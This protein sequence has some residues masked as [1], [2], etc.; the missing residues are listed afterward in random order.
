MFCDRA[1]RTLSLACFVC[2]VFS[3]A[4]PCVAD[5]PEPALKQTYEGK[6]VV[7]RNFWPGNLLKF[8]ASGQLKG[9]ASPGIW[10]LHGFIRVEKLEMDGATLRLRCKRLVI[11]ETRDGFDYRNGRKDARLEIDLDLDSSE[12]RQEAIRA[13]FSRMF[14]SDKIGFRDSVPTYWRDC[15]TT[16]LAGTELKR[17]EGCRFSPHLAGIIGVQTGAQPATVAA[18]ATRPPAP[19]TAAEETIDGEQIFKVKKGVVLAPKAVYALDPEYTDEARAEG[20]NGSCALEVV[21]DRSGQTR[22]VQIQSP[23]GYG[24]DEAAII[25]V[26]SWK[27]APGI[28]DGHPV[29]VKATVVFSFRDY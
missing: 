3:L 25:A 13:A 11:G 21:I 22:A 8:D 15:I 12:S 29:S 1:T 27:F 4:L 20:V 23:I 6:V 2:V 24:L 9:D 10:T 26:G 19:A 5:E 14:V 17:T 18:Q 16:A 7:I 28:K